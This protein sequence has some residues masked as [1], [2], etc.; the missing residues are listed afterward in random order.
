MKK[1][2]AGSTNIV[3]YHRYLTAFRFGINNVPANQVL[4]P[5]NGFNSPSDLL[6][7]SGH[8]PS[9]LMRIKLP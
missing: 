1:K 9:W 8:M 3:A 2:S 5:Y 6:N 7:F 4:L